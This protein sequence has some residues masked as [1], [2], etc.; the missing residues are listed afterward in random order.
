MSKVLDLWSELTGVVLDYALSTPPS[1]GWLMCYGQAL[2]AG[3]AATDRL[4]AKLIADGNPY[5]VDASNNPKVSDVRGRV[6]AGKDNMG[7]TAA[8]RVTGAEA[9]FDGAVLG[10]AGGSQTHTLT[11]TQVPAHSHGGSAAS[12]G[13]HSHTI[14]ITPESRAIGGA[15]TYAYLLNTNPT[16]TTLAGAHTHTITTDS[17][18]GDQAHPNV[19]P[20]LVL[21]KIIKL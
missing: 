3:N 1:S 14:N 19:Q 7:G 5:G 2:T 11:S 20:S 10:A 4:R 13:Q 12:A 21:N 9:G 8:G 16:S 17:K 15:E 18:G 6:V